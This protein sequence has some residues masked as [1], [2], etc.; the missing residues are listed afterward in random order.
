MRTG[1]RRSAKVIISRELPDIAFL[2]LVCGV[3]WGKPR[4]PR[5]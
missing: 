3:D 2:F 1:K 4:E 5:F